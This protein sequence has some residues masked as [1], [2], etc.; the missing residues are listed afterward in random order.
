[1]L[2]RPS[3]AGFDELLRR[4]VAAWRERW[5]DAAVSIGGDPHAELAL[6]FSMYHMM[7]T[8]HPTKE[9]VSVGARGLSGLSYFNHV[10]WDTEIFVVPFFIYTHPET[11]RTLLAYRFRNL[12]GARRKA[13]DMGFKGALFPWESADKGIETTPPYGIGP[14]GEMIPI[15][16]GLLEHHISADVGW[17]AWEYWKGTGDDEFMEHMG[18]EL[19]LETARF[20]A[21]RASPRRARPLSHQHGRGAR[22]VPRGRRRQRLHQRP[23]ALQHRA[24]PRRLRLAH[25][26]RPRRRGRDRASASA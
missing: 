17:A 24:R 11:A 26:A 12:D 10:F 16:S 7:S 15:L 13:H 8:A 22:R 21:S 3:A 9:S 5:A 19:L 1:M 4:H 2:E 18:A 6:R 14:H 20:W 25:R 23:R